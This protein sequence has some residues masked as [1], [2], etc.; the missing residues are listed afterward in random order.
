MSLFKYLIFR[1]RDI[2]KKKVVLHTLDE[3]DQYFTH[4]ESLF[5][6]SHDEGLKAL[7]QM[8]LK[9][10]SISQMDPWSPEYRNQHLDL[11]ASISGRKSYDPYECERNEF[12]L[13]DAIR[14]PYPYQTGSSAQLG[15]QLIAQGHVIRHLDLKPGDKIIE[16]GAGWGN[17]TL[18]I[19]QLGYDVTAVEIDTNSVALMK[20]RAENAS[21]PLTVIQSGML[22]FEPPTQYDRVIFYESFHHCDDPFAMLDKVKEMLTPG[23]AAVFA[24]EPIGIFPEPWG[25]RLDGLSLW[26]IRKFGWLELGFERQ[27]WE[28]L[29]VRKGFDFERKRIRHI[30]IADLYLAKLHS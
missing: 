24:S 14:R 16:F 27:F 9:P 30:P 17:L 19:A 28:A 29:L 10:G 8:Y 26:S 5:A 18:Q 15:E 13:E 7:Q 6:Q 22:D 11:Y 1:A 20:R 25:L 3:L 21:I 4:V 23:G 2:V 12:N